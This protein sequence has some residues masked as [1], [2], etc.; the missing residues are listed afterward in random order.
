MQGARTVRDVSSDFLQ[1]PGMA[2]PVLLPL[3][4]ENFLFSLLKSPFSKL[5]IVSKNIERRVSRSNDK[6][7]IFWKIWNIQDEI[8]IFLS[9]P[10]IDRTVSCFGVAKVSWNGMI[11]FVGCFRTKWSIVLVKICIDRSRGG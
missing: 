1:M 8:K 6:G 7:I 11:R 3:Q 5:V 2:M 9:Q 10:L 4:R